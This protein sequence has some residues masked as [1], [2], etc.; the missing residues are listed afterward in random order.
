MKA[1]SVIALFVGLLG[2]AVRAGGEVPC[3]RSEDP[4]VSKIVARGL[5]ESATFRQLYQQLENSSNLIVHLRRG[6]DGKV[7]S[8]YNQFVAR[9]GSY[10]FVRITINVA[11]ANDAAI[12]LLGHELRHAVEVAEAEAVD[13]GHDYQRLY[14]RIGYS[15]CRQAVRRCY[16]T[17]EAVTTGREIMRELL[18]KKP[19]G[20][21]TAVVA[22]QLIRRWAEGGAPLANASE[23]P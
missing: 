23:A 21:A 1:T 12:A 16:E 3:L 7:G 13:D 22:A 11:Q 18:Q 9:A 14:E 6:S 15:S 2:G 19:A 4:L 5:R 10:R 8:G 20:V 17:N